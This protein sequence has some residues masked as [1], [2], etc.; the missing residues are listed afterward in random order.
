MATR[1]KAPAARPRRT[2]PAPT[3]DLQPVLEQGL[4]LR[5][6]DRPRLQIEGDYTIVNLNALSREYKL[7]KAYARIRNL[8][9]RSQ[10]TLRLQTFADYHELQGV[11]LRA[12]F[13]VEIKP[14]PKYPSGEAYRDSKTARLYPNGDMLILVEASLYNSIAPCLDQYVLDVGRDGYWATVHAVQGG[15]PADIRNYLHSRGPAGALLIGAI[16][17]PWYRI[18]KDFHDVPAEFPCD[19]Y[20][21]DTNGTWLDPDNDGKFN[22][23][24]GD[25]NPEIWVGRLWTPTQNGND[26]ALINDYLARNHKFR[27]GQLGHARSALAF[28]DDAWGFGNCEMDQM[29][30]ASVITAITDPLKTDADLYKA[31]VNSL[32]SWVQLCA[33]SWPQGHALHVGNTDEYIDYK[34]FRDTNPPNAHFYNLFCCGPGL[35]TTSDYIAGWYIFDKAGG[36]TNNGLTAIAS[37]KS[38]SMLWFADFYRP[39]GQ[40]KVIGDAYVDWWKARGPDHDSGE[41][42]W[43]YGLTLLG[44]PTLT[45]WKGAVPVP[46]QPQNGDVFDHYPRNMQLR[47]SPVNL[48]G[49]TYTVE[50][51]FFYNT[52][53]EETGRATYLYHNLAT[54]TL[55]HV[56][57]GAQPGRWR[58]RAKVDN[59]FCSWSPWSYFRFTV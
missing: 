21:M 22:D 58:V 39:L 34:Y 37:S 59:T 49:V 24:T 54:T 2:R 50:I 27:L 29:F 7:A 12:P 48:P 13:A 26:A 38:G 1:K 32:R 10:K 40:G 47:W 41:R 11:S 35:Y 31:E 14:R 53:A 46:E 25:L 5:D 3:T 56:F 36:G 45:W 44:D 4:Q 57:V 15:G 33:H 28:V 19:L 23:H 6:S 18:E 42:S 51:D 20:Y 30:P 9:F 8:E 17:A 52:W 43:H 55:D 16:A